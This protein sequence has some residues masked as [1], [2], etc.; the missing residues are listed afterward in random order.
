MP[1]K[2]SEIIKMIQADGWYLA[3]TRGSHRQY[4]HP[5]KPGRVTVAGKPSDTLHPAH[6]TEHPETS[7][8]QA[9][10]IVSQYVVIIERDEAG[11]YSAW[12]PDLPGVIAAASSYDEVMK[13]MRKAVAFH[14]EGMRE[15]GEP[16][17]A[18]A[19]IG[20]ETIIAA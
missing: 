13:L 7:T 4:K 15:D 20:A 16:I 5:G 3:A 18:P 9:E 8:D 6:R 12:A 17:P 14:L 2:V 10:A 19:A 11:G 1:L